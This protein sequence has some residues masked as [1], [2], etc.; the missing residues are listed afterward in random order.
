MQILKQNT[1]A[2]LTIGPILDSAGAE[3]TGAVIGD[4]SISKN[5]TTSALGSP[6]T[7]THIG[8]GFYTLALATGNTDTL[9]R[10]SL[11]CNKSTYQM[12]PRHLTVVTAE[13]FDTLITNGTLAST[14]SGRTITTDAAGYVDANTVRLGGV[15]QTGR[16][17]G[18]SVLLSSG[19]GAGE[20]DLSSGQVKV[21]SGTGAGQILSSSGQVTVG[22][23][24]DKSGYALSSAGIQ[25]IWDALTSALTTVNSIGKRLV[26]NIDAA[27]SSRST[28]AG[29]DTPGTTTLLSKIVG[30]LAA[31]THNPQSGDAYARL[32]APAG[33]S[34]SADIAAVKTDTSSTLTNSNT[35]LNRIGAFTGSGINTILGF[36]RALAR[37]DSGLTPSDMGGTFDNT[38]D[39]M[40][41][42]TDNGVKLDLTQSVPTSNTAQTVGDALNAARAQGFGKWVLSGTTLTLYAADGTTV[43][44][45]FTLDSGT[46]PTQ[47]T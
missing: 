12:P 8:N 40:E 5:G 21:Q 9:G 11:Y 10:L 39:S 22:T 15:V 17:I 34:V 45:T 18:A 29:G 24:N 23:N 37:K 2:T 20:I 46:S 16:N 43:V 31:G 28:Y 32:G 35:I 47:R 33:A 36:F 6:A 26:D 3:Y 30:T 27:I 41:A 13:V 44:R 14:T 1:A 25:A 19:T 38:T 42:R 4:I 7:L